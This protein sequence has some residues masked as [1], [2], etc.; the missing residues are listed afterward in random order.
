[1]TKDYLTPFEAA[2]YACV[3]LADFEALANECGILSFNFMGP[4]VYR[5]A[6]IQGGYGAG[7]ATIYWRGRCA[8]LN[9]V[10]AGERHR[11]SLGAVTAAEAEAALTGVERRLAVH[12]RRPVL[13]SPSGRSSTR[14]GT[15]RVSRQLLPSRA[16]PALLPDPVLR[17]HA[18]RRHHPPR[19]R[20][21]QARAPGRSLVRHRHEGAAHPAGG[22]EQGRRLG[23]HPGQSGQGG[24]TTHR[25]RLAAATLVHPRGPRSHLRAERVTPKSGGSWSTPVCGAAR[26]NIFAGKMSAR[27]RSGWFDPGR[28]NEV[29]EVA[30]G[31]HHPRRSNSAGGAP[32]GGELVVPRMTPFSL[33]HG[34]SRTLA[35]VAID[36]SLHCLR[37]T[38]CTHLVIA[39]VALRTVQVLTGHSTIPVT[40]RYAHLA[41]GHLMDATKGL[42]L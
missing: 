18:D 38:Y 9:W 22:D 20:G 27:T 3:P 10:E 4:M 29:S 26:L 35:R 17:P 7:M 23:D 1:M 41:P 42:S 11:E 21:V 30:V 2:E 31:P 5:K 37:H 13:S 32:R 19:G 28:A 33:T 15:G 12:I 36:G 39:G 40:E 8:Y 6:D 24:Q 16:D 25:P 14:H 34:F